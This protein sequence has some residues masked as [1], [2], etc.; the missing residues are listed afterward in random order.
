M[1]TTWKIVPAPRFAAMREW[2]CHF[3]GAEDLA[4]PVFLSRDGRAVVA[5]GTGCAAEALGIT[6]RQV[7]A[8]AEALVAEAEAAEALR[9]Q[10]AENKARALAAFEAAPNGDDPYLAAARQ[11]YHRLGGFARL[12]KF[13]AW[14]AAVAETGDLEATAAD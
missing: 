7:V 6:R 2:D 10:V 12:G 1:T 14:L 8:E 3:C 5:A 13:S 11:D 9:R 4:K